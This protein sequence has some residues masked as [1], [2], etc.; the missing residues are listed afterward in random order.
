MIKTSKPCCSLIVAASAL[1]LWIDAAIADSGPDAASRP[2]LQVADALTETI[3]DYRFDN[4]VRLQRVDPQAGTLL[5]DGSM[6]LVVNEDKE[7]GPYVV[8]RIASDGRL[9]AR[10]EVFDSS[11]FGGDVIPGVILMPGAGAETAALNDAAIIVGAS[12][13]GPRRF[14][15]A[16][17]QLDFFSWADKG[18]YVSSAFASAPGEVWIGG[19]EDDINAGPPCSRA[20]LVRADGRGQESWRWYFDTAPER[21]TYAREIVRLRDDT[22]LLRIS[23]S[24]PVGY[25]GGSSPTFCRE[26]PYHDW[27]AWL[28]PTGETIQTKAL[29]PDEYFGL[30]ALPND[31]IALSGLLG[32]RN[33]PQRLFLR[34]L[35]SATGAVLHDQRYDFDILSG[36]DERESV[37]TWP[38]GEE[39]FLVWGLLAAGERLYVIASFT[40]QIEHE[41]SWR[42]ILQTDL[43]GNVRWVSDRLPESILIGASEDGHAMFVAS[44][45]GV[46]RIP[47]L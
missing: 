43:D 14:N 34:I 3:W 42:R 22:L 23:T 36:L 33:L 9:L 28:S 15:L 44:S 1:L 30:A 31:R 13:I 11:L 16:G 2:M 5:P 19:G 6:I 17:Q 35:D 41:G 37:P 32:D 46:Y 8:Y 39:P 18:P 47:V 29:P 21:A 45:S 27:F 4:G 40:T 12:G 25:S 26:Y 7:L 10:L 20:L 38:V 24:P